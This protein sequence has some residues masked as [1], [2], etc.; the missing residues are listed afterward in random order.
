M[1]RVNAVWVGRAFLVLAAI[2]AVWTV[3]LGYTLPN[4][5][6]LAHQEIVWVGFDL[7]LLVGLV[8]IAWT[9]LRGSRFLPLA[10]AATAALLVMDAWFDVVGSGSEGELLEA[11]LM[12]VLV[13]LPL[14]GICWWVAWHSQ[15]VLE[16]RV[17][18]GIMHRQAEPAADQG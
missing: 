18:A 6:E 11:L 5:G 1:S 4:K 13:E 9:A 16:Q 8:A 7:G 12:A 14:S 2:L 10:A 3:V 17:A 15:T